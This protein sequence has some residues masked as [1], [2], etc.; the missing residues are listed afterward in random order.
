MNWFYFN[1]LLSSP[2]WKGWLAKGGLLPC[3]ITVAPRC[4]SGD[5]ISPTHLDH[6]TATDEWLQPQR[7][8]GLLWCVDYRV[9]CTNVFITAQVGGLSAEGSGL[10]GITSSVSVRL[11]ESHTRAGFIKCTKLSGV[12]STPQGSLLSSLYLL[13]NHLSPLNSQS[14]SYPQSAQR[15]R[16][17]RLMRYVS[18]GT[19]KVKAGAKQNRYRWDDVCMIKVTL[20]TLIRREVT[21]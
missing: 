19:Q 17:R 12:Q 6:Q 2:N 8:R 16:H 20:Q 5:P 21:L 18:T 9:V 7:R 15:R 1:S 14:A 10:N 11:W 4:A 3:A 13:I